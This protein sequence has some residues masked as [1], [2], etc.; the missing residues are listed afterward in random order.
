MHTSLTRFNIFSRLL[1]KNMMKMLA[2]AA[3]LLAVPC[4]LAFDADAL[5]EDEHGLEPQGIHIYKNR[6]TSF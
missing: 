6:Q 2:Q 1:Q 5:A 4:L 3:G